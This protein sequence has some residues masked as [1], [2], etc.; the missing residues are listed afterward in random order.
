[1]HNA[2][3]HQSGDCLDGAGQWSS[4]NHDRGLGSRPR[5]R[6]V[7]PRRCTRRSHVRAAGCVKPSAQRAVVP[8]SNASKLLSRG[9]PAGWAV[10]WSRFPDPRRVTLPSSPSL[11]PSGPERSARSSPRFVNN[12]SPSSYWAPCPRPV[13]P[14]TCPRDLSSNICWMHGPHLHIHYCPMYDQF[15]LRRPRRPS[16]HS[17][18][19]KISVP[20]TAKHIPRNALLGFVPLAQTLSWKMRHDPNIPEK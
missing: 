4:V 2:G 7:T 3:H 5:H 13:L 11:D 12:D 16:S 9:P 1:M 15:L 14:P 6:S 10:P 20:R 18:S 19:L 8:P 17:H